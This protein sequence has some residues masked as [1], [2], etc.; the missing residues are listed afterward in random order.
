MNPS[1]HIQ[2]LVDEKYYV[3]IIEEKFLL[4]KRVPYLNK[5]KEIQYCTIVS[6]LE[7]NGNDVKL[8]PQHPIYFIG[9]QPYK[10]NGDKFNPNHSNRTE[11][12][13]GLIANFYFSY[14]KDD[15]PYENYYDKMT[16]YVHLFSKHAIHVDPTVTFNIGSL[17]EVPRSSPFQ[18]SDCNSASPEVNVL[19]HKFSEMRVGIIGMGGT[20]SYILD[21]IAKT[22]VKE[23]HLFDGDYYH[24]KNAFR[25]PGATHIDSLINVQKKTEFFQNQ[26]FNIHK[27]VISHPVNICEDNL[28]ELDN[29]SFVFISIDKSSIKKMITEHLENN[30]IDFIDVGMGVKIVNDSILGQIRITTSTIKKRGH[31]HTNNRIKFS[32]NPENDYS[33]L[34]QIAE[35]NAF[36][37]AQAVIKWK[38]LVGFY[39]DRGKEFHTIYQLHLNKILNFDNE[40]AP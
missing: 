13:P 17:V 14:R 27:G 28:A 38:K 10:A 35:L 1:P 16:H 12:L 36:N 25:S 39:H 19:Y 18:Y 37:A 11:L 40:T 9:E 33:K 32:E 8:F 31:I 3:E 15:K 20:G 29:L 4:I 2:K 21:Y 6:E 7:L 34:P 23:I 30:G 22:P 24:N 5:E 26:Y